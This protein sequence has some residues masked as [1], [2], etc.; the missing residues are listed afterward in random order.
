[1]TGHSGRTENRMY[2]MLDGDIHVVKQGSLRDIKNVIIKQRSLRDIK[3]FIVKRH[4]LY[5]SVY[6]KLKFLNLQVPI[7]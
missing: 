5:T 3:N 6:S 4:N 1:M 2:L 7:L